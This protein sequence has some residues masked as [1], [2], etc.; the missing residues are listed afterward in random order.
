MKN[1]ASPR[2]LIVLP[3]YMALASITAHGSFLR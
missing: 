2:S 3:P 1:V